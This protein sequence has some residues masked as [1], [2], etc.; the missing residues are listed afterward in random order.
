[1][2]SKLLN[3]MAACATLLVAAGVA[4]ADRA[5]RGTDVDLKAADGTRLKATYYSA[6]KPGPGIIL[7]HMCNSKRTAWA[8]LGPRLAAR[9]M[10]ALAID[11][12][13]Y[14]DSGGKRYTE[15]SPE[16]R[17]RM[18]DQTWPSDIDAALTYLASRPGVDAGRIGAAGG[19]CGVNQAIQ[20]AR[21]H[22]EV[23]TVVLLA[24]GAT[25]AGEDHLA[26]TPWMPVFAVAAHDDGDA[27]EQM[28]WTIGFSSNPANRLKTYPK[29]GHGTE[30]FAVHADLEPAI[31]SWFE[32]YLITR[33]V[34][35]AAGAP[36]PGPSARQAAELRAPGGTAR[37]RQRLRESRKAGKPPSLPPEPAINLL[38]YEFMQGG[39][40]QDAI[41][42]FELNVEAH[43]ESANAHDSLADGYLAAK[44]RGR[45]QA[46]ARKAL[47]LLARDKNVSEDF[48]KEIRKS[49]EAKLKA[50]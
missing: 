37:I 20:L 36:K 45:A 31:V 17:A 48:R 24:G 44:D 15:W 12:R 7:L 6:G 25:T 35:A 39:R 13:G 21:R 11:Y 9:G 29:G 5:G 10:H 47:E 14:G 34:R 18:A 2:N 8:T 41:Q 16:E 4:H 22:S 46:H 27:V 23:K 3:S 42:L 30:L 26:R 43:P 38:G 32:Q 28:Q 33:P 19:S 49:A 50:K 40:V 1:M